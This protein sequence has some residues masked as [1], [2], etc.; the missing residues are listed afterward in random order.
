MREHTLTSSITMGV[1]VQI[2]P[3]FGRSDYGRSMAYTQI[4]SDLVRGSERLPMGLHPQVTD[5]YQP[6]ASKPG[7]RHPGLCR[8]GSGQMPVASATERRQDCRTST[9][10]KIV[11][12]FSG[13]RSL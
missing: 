5:R 9:F 13:P 1:T 4:A 11:V 6:L 12:A 7:I 10:V 2:P 8:E 3:P